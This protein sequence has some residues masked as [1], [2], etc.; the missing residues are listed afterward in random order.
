MTGDKFIDN[1][2]INL[3]RNSNAMDIIKEQNG[4][5]HFLTYKVI[6]G[7]FH[8]RFFISS[9]YS[10]LIANFHSNLG[11]AP[12]P[13][14]WALGFHQSRWGYNSSKQLKTVIDNFEK[15]QIPLETIWSDIDYMSD[16]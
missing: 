2:H 9:L 14:F 11:F 8:F 3:L 10:R 7:I 5:R 4:T 16:F 12:I 13:P 1:P 15:N 6:G